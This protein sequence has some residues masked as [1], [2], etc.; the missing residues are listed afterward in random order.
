MWSCLAVQGSQGSSEDS[1]P[2]DGDSQSEA[3]NRATPATK[4]RFIDTWTRT[5]RAHSHIRSP[6]TG[7]KKEAFEEG[8]LPGGGAWALGGGG[9]F[10]EDANL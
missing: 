4:N 9:G 2:G 10:R 8:V 5:C 6:G 7:R 3:S 1:N